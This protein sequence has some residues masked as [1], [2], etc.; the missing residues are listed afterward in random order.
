MLIQQETTTTFKNTVGNGDVDPKELINLRV[1]VTAE[2]K[3]NAFE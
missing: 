1:N 3:E 2:S